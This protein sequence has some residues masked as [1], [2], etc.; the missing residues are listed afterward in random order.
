MSAATLLSQART[1]LSHFAV[2]GPSNAIAAHGHGHIHD[3]FAALV[4]GDDGWRR[5]LLQ[6]FNTAVFPDPETVLANVAAVTAHLRR[7][8]PERG[9]DAERRAPPLGP[10]RRGGR[11]RRGA[12][13]AG[14][15]LFPFPAGATDPRR[16]PR[17]PAAPA[18]APRFAP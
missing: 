6:R 10:P 12:Q 18:P 5:Y 15:R 4:E 9:V 11:P 16:A 13:G 14:P 7:R 2:A 3:S 1:V 8:L 17:P